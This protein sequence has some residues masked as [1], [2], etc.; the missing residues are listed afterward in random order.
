MPTS[1]AINTAAVAADKIP[2][3]AALRPMNRAGFCLMLRVT[4]TLTI[5]SAIRIGIAGHFT[6][7]AATSP[8]ETRLQKRGQLLFSTR[9][10]INIPRNM[11]STPKPA[12]N[13]ML[14]R[15]KDGSSCS[16]LASGGPTARAPHAGQPTQRSALIVEPQE[17]QII[18]ANKPRKDWKSGNKLERAALIVK[19]LEHKMS[20]DL[21][22][23]QISWPYAPASAQAG[24]RETAISQR[25]LPGQRP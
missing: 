17:G 10:A 4:F 7:Q 25:Y 14:A 3:R 9:T 12:A 1:V 8:A 21:V 16:A 22:T 11:H 15:P 18:N 5:S 24:P 6:R 20:G 19:T 2:M 13:T 23:R